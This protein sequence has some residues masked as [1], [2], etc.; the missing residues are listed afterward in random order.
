ME[1]PM[2]Q[3][4]IVNQSKSFEMIEKINRLNPATIRLFITAAASLLFIPFLGGVHLFDW[5]EI[6]FAESAR[7]MIV[8]GDY[9]TVHINFQRFWEKPPLF[10]W[11]QVLSMKLFGINEFAARFPNAI[12]G[13]VTLLVLFNIGKKIRNNL[14]GLLW[15][16]AYAG[17]VLPFFYFKSGIIDPWFNLFIFLGVYFLM[18]YAF[19]ENRQKIRNII[20][21]ATFAG[22]AVLTK[23]PVGFLLIALTGGIF[24]LWV[25]FKVKVRVMD[26]I[27][28]FIVLALVGGSW[29]IIQIL[30]GNFDTVVE[31]IVY[32]VRLFQTQDAG[33]GGFF[34]YHFVVLFFGVFPSSILALKAFG[35][36]PSDETFYP[37]MKKWMVI[38]FWVVLILFSIVK[39]KIVHYSSL[40]YFPLTFLAA[41]FVYRAWQNQFR[42]SKWISAIIIAISVLVA[43]PVMLLSFV[44][45]FK[46]K[47]IDSNLI[48]DQ[49]AV[50]NLKAE[51]NWTGFE[52]LPGLLFLIA[53]ILIF[54]RIKKTEPL[55]RAVYLWGT[56]MFFALSVILA[57]VPR[58]EKY[59][60]NALIEFFKSKAGDDVY[61]KNIHFKSYATYFYGETLP[62]S[63][64]NFY[65]EN[66]LLT[67]D[68]D[69]D[70]HFATKI[71]RAPLMEKY[72][73]I[74]ETGRKNGFVFYVR[75]TKK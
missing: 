62:S 66:W 24:L 71:H 70:V 34:G 51:A 9:L 32:Q 16:L 22:L 60:Q 28:Y 40:A 19:P 25:K 49:F 20:L 29:F 59:S 56:T 33:H 75:K 63:N 47:I 30:T 57:L 45:K 67:G 18:L 38:L 23:G 72:D 8:T 2:A 26:V 12:C 3:Q 73:D 43:V 39:T 35:K 52:F 61:L 69:K 36:E 1:N 41:G 14:F 74:E 68:I 6:N 10:I 65:D 37:F 27:T 21:A 58:I 15:V 17:S 50:E 55:K 48:H 13:I 54:T 4:L 42:W 46:Y 64:P 44:N 31:F 5:D 11:M 7:E 53:I